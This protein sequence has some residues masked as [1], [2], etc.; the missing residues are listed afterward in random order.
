MRKAKKVYFRKFQKRKLTRK[1]K[2]RLINKIIFGTGLFLFLFF[3]YFFIFSPYFQVKE[4]EIS[5]VFR[6]ISPDNFRKEVEDSITQRFLFWANKNIIFIREENLEKKM[7]EKNPLIQSLKLEKDYPDKIILEI[8]ERMPFGILETLNGRFIFDQEGVI[9]LKEH[10]E[11]AKERLIKIKDFSKEASVGQ[12]YFAEKEIR[13]F[14][15]IRDFF[16]N[17]LNIEIQ[18]IDIS[19]PDKIIIGTKEGWKVFLTFKQNFDIIL[20]KLEI[21]LIDE[22]PEEKREKLDYIDLRFEKIFYKYRR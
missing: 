10:T 15:Q 18:E 3:L 6:L 20:S 2:Q 5:G 13:Q 11:S 14:Q 16:K 1:E 9:F 12:G 21:L 22:I 4:I 8:Y 7:K 17:R 19:D